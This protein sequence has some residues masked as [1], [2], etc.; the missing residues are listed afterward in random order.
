MEDSGFWHQKWETGKIGF[1]RET[2]HPSLVK[3]WPKAS[4]EKH[5]KVLV[6]LC[7]KTKDMLWL[8]EQGH[9]VIGVELSAIAATD[10]FDD[11]QIDYSVKKLGKFQCYQGGKIS[12]L[13]GD[14]FDLKPANI[15]GVTA[16][17]DR[18]AII[19]LPTQMRKRYTKHLRRLLAPQ[20][21]ILVI[22][23]SYD[24]SLM[25]GPPFSVSEQ[26]IE[27]LYGDWC[28]ISLLH[29][30]TPEDFRGIEAYEQTFLIT[31]K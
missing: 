26:E 25:D 10:F 18:A 30:S 15:H 23:L 14:F 22:T 31:S 27:G 4:R 5:G 2:N 3:F 13:V 11:N 24:Q 16:V 29:S 19:A 20:T 7:G 21:T 17:Y 12:I 6:P 8:A 9:D 28:E 1:H